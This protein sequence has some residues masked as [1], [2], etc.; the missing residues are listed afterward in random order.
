[1]LTLLANGIVRPRDPCNAADLHRVDQQLRVIDILA[2]TS[3]R[4]DLLEKKEFV[5][6]M[7]TWTVRVLQRASQQPD[8]DLA[9]LP[10]LKARYAPE[11]GTRSRE[12]D[13]DI[14]ALFGDWQPILDDTLHPDVFPLDMMAPG[15]PWNNWSTSGEHMWA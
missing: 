15:G 11:V 13:Q 4:P 3:E 6:L 5:L 12:A 1:M 2:T 14:D 7:R 9:E 8:F 10:C